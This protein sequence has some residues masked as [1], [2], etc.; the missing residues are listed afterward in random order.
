MAMMSYVMSQTMSVD[1]KLFGSSGRMLQL[2]KRKEKTLSACI[3]LT[4]KVYMYV[5]F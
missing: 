3:G 2:E 5:S 4:R 1:G